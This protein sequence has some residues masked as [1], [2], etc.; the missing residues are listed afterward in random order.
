MM[1]AFR[2]VAAIAFLVLASV[3]GF[4]GW[5]PSYLRV[6]AYVLCVAQLVLGAAALWRW[7]RS[8]AAS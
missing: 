3:A 4:P 8:N 7:H 2:V 5:Y 6:A 1:V